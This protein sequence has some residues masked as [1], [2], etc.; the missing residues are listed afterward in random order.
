MIVRVLFHFASN[1][2][3]NLICFQFYLESFKLFCLMLQEA[4]HGY[5]KVHNLDAKIAH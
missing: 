5:C 2:K 4:P 3:C 1:T